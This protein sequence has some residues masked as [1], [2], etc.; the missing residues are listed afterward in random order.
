MEKLDDLQFHK[1]AV[2]QRTDLYRFT[3]D[4]V[5]L[6]DFVEVK[7][8]DYVVDFGTGCGI[9]PILLCAKKELKRVTGI[10]IQPEMVEL[11][12]KS[13]AY[14]HLEDKFEVLNCK[15][16]M[17]H[18]I[19]PKHPDVVVCNP[20]YRKVTEGE[21]SKATSN[22]I[23]KF[24]VMIDLSEIV[25]SARRNLKVGGRFYMVHRADRFP[26]IISCLKRNDLAP[27]KIQFVH[28]KPNSLAHLVMIEA[29]S[30]GNCQVKI[31]PSLVLQNEDGTESDEV[32]KIYSR[33]E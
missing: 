16:Q 14:N 11:C 18:K 17:S 28:A 13:I 24:E 20:P 9:I 12:Q 25:E 3:G 23:A 21:T 33:G 5:F 6:A 10:E 4:A 2:Y 27:R 29:V 7:K 8:N 32:V 22:Q 31:L 1:F 26:E 30:G 19:L 15:I